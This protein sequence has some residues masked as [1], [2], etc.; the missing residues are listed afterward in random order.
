VTLRDIIRNL[1]SFQDDQVIH[2]AEPWIGESDAIVA[3]IPDDGVA[4]ESNLPYFLEMQIVKQLV[5][6]LEEAFGRY[7]SETET[8]DRVIAYARTDA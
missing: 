2:A 3:T 4:V 7:P 6:D 5:E 1:R 8:L